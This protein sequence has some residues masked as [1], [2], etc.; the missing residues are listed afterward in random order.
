MTT[1]SAA[2][3][4]LRPTLEL[5]LP[6]VVGQV[7]QMLIGLTDTAFIGR[8]GAV[9]L[10][11]ACTQGLI[12]VFYVVGIGLLF[13][14]GVFTA[15]DR[16]AHDEVACMSWL[17]HGRALALAVSLVGFGLLAF[18]STQFDRLAQP[19]EVMAIASPFFC[20]SR[21]RSCPR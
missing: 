15:Q 20:S 3:R 1:I 18:V 10:A 9:P 13:G 7:S 8:L 17:R 21:P 19:P 14:P 11:A 16:S 5:A 4:E 6:I 12:R 2:R